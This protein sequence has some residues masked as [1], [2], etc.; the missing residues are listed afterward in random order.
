MSQD[1]L[2]T[3][4]FLF[5]E[6]KMTSNVNIEKVID[7]FKLMVSNEGDLFYNTIFFYINVL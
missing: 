1:G 3:L 4:L 6:Q 2:N 5:V 7:Q